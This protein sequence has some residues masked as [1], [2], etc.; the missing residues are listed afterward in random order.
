MQLQINCTEVPFHTSQAHFPEKRFV[1]FNFLWIEPYGPTTLRLEILAAISHLL[2]MFNWQ[3]QLCLSSICLF[4]Q[5]PTTADELKWPQ[6]SFSKTKHYS[7]KHGVKGLGLSKQKTFTSAFIFQ[8]QPQ[9]IRLYAA[10]STFRLGGSRWDCLFCF[11]LL[12]CTSES[13]TIFPL[14]SCQQPTSP[15]F[16]WISIWKVLMSC[17]GLKN[18]KLAHQFDAWQRQFPIQNFSVSF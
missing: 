15:P 10:T 8:S 11:S 17:L 5:E 3:T 14:C 16:P 7:L 6:A 13:A 4:F 12:M 18:G 2:L 9:W 1:T